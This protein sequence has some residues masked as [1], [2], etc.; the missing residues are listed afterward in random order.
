MGAEQARPKFFFQISRSL[1][2]NIYKMFEY[3]TESWVRKEKKIEIENTVSPK[4]SNESFLEA[5]WI[6]S[7]ANGGHR[8]PSN[9]PHDLVSHSS[10]QR[11]HLSS[12]VPPCFFQFK[13][14]RNLMAKKTKV[15]RNSLPCFSEAT[16]FVPV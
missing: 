3:V 13:A 7:F 4:K 15:L 16:N 12:L 10:C 6:N 9:N 14:C 1:S 5:V 11:F 8:K 2:D